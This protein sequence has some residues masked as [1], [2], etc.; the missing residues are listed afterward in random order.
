METLAP[1]E[2]DVASMRRVMEREGGCIAWSGTARISPA[3]VDDSHAD[4]SAP[5]PTLGCAGARTQIFAHRRS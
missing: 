5:E 1:V 3:D 4:S 2:L